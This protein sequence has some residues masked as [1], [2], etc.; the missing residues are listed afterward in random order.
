MGQLKKTNI[1]IT[2]NRPPME[3]VVFGSPLKVTT[4]ITDSEE[5][6][7]HTWY[8]LTTPNPSSGNLSSHRSAK[9]EF[10]TTEDNIEVEF[11]IKA[12]TNWDGSVTIST[13]DYY[14][15]G[16]IDADYSIATIYGNLVE[17]IIKYKVPT[18]GKH[19]IQFEYS[20]G[21][22]NSGD[23]AYICAWSNL[24]MPI[25]EVKSVYVENSKIQQMNV[26]G[27]DLFEYGFGNT[28]SWETLEWNKSN[29]SYTYNTKGKLYISYNNNYVYLT[30][31]PA[32]INTKP[33]QLS[34][35]NINN[36][37]GTSY[38]CTY[39]LDL[40]DLDISNI[41][42]MGRMFGQCDALTSVN[43]T[44]WN[45]SKVTDMEWMFLWCNSLTNLDVSNFDTSNVTNTNRMF[46]DCFLLSNIDVSRW[47]TSKMD[48]VAG[49]FNGCKSLTSLD[50]S[51]WNTTNISKVYDSNSG[52]T[53]LFMNCENLVDLKLP[54]NFITSKVTNI[55]DMFNGC[56]K[57]TS[58]DLS[59]WDTSKITTMNNMFA[60][61]GKIN[62]IDLS[63]WDLSSL[64]VHVD[65]WNSGFRDV[66]K[67]SYCE[68]IKLPNM[69]FGKDAKYDFSELSYLKSFY[70]P[71]L[72]N[73]NITSVDN[74]FYNDKKLNYVDMHD[75]D[76]SNVTYISGMFGNCIE[77]T[78]I[79][80]S[81][82]DVSKVTNMYNMFGGCSSL[83]SLD[84][85]NWN[86]S[87]VT[88]MNDTFSRC[89]ELK[90]L[91]A[92]HESETNVTA[93]N[94]L[95]V[96]IDLSDCTKLNDQ[97]I[98]AICMG[99]ANL[100]S[101]NKKTITVSKTKENN[102]TVNIAMLNARVKNWNAVY[103]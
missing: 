4:E 10:T 3:N 91:I 80:T 70:A 93:L 35:N 18:K 69:N 15:D 81:T 2:G 16:V 9:I 33:Y 50:L 49:M 30:N 11:K 1:Y 23:G 8:K 95:K 90:T 57:L 29:N 36:Y 17:K 94:G 103:K 51:R 32:S 100:P 86:V 60:Y 75:W 14:T 13:L 34:F 68:N 62:M 78:T 82:W 92:G 98:M 38:T 12:Q 83:T 48:D 44:D 45:T 96:D 56:K 25:S 63:N 73:A 24:N 7:K 5:N 88:S 19:F 37:Y 59:G 77:L 72:V 102:N 76:F 54:K 52:G 74:M 61:T 27:K 6:K 43:V 67:G 47:N 21:S 46:E 89:S 28:I 40:S 79:D 64:K 65:R 26:Q 66:F 22:N 101:D 39:K 41:N 31:S 20:K 85:S 97:S 58:L 84:L 87:N 71:Q 99:L 42:N 55:S 53:G